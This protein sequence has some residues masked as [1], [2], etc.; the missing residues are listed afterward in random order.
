[1][2]TTPHKGIIL[3]EVIIAMG[4]F[5]TGVV[6]LIVL[7][8]DSGNNSHQAVVRTQATLLAQ[9]GLEAVRT[10]RD[11]D[12]DVLVNGTYGIVL[13]NGVWTL[14]DTPDVIDQFTRTITIADG[15]VPETK[16]ITTQ[17]V[18]EIN[19]V[20]ETDITVSELV[21]DWHKEP[22]LDIDC[23]DVDLSGASIEQGSAHKIIRYI[24]ISNPSCSRTISLDKLV[25]TWNSSGNFFKV[26]INSNFL[27]QGNV[28]TGTIMDLVPNQTLVSGA[29]AIEI[30]QLRWF[31]SILGTDIGV[32]FIM[33][34]GSS[35]SFV[36]P[37][38]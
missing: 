17:V 2:T 37:A 35:E 20:S 9:E 28:P 1:M 6:M 16:L 25:L 21:S 22:V 38:F 34:D 10:M 31:Q 32:E 18:W 7:N 4:V 8:F 13:T 33:T 14:D 15:T 29:P 19:G 3:L 23:F 30:D 24:W 36:I 27:F 11:T 12:F 26:R 5:L